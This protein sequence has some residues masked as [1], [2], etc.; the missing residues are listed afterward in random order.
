[1][2]NKLKNFLFGPSATDYSNDIQEIS[3]LIKRYR[4]LLAI[5]RDKI[6]GLGKLTAASTLLASIHKITAKYPE[7]E[8]LSIVKLEEHITKSSLR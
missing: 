3:K 8:N 4:N 5:G 1:M 7:L 6:S 2:L